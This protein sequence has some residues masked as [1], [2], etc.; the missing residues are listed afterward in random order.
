M[1]NLINGSNVGDCN[2]KKKKLNDLTLFFF[3]AMTIPF[4]LQSPCGLFFICV[5]RKAGG[6]DVG[7]LFAQMGN[8]CNLVELKCI[9]Y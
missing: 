4:F 5:L 3:L 2:G 1:A 6:W 8:R 7:Y 9:R